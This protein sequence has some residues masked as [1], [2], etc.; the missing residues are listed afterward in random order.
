MLRR[1]LAVTSE[2]RE[3]KNVGKTQKFW[4]YAATL[5]A[6]P[7]TRPDSISPKVILALHRFL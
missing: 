6:Y 4:D 1:A 7:E 3:K 2:E 5:D